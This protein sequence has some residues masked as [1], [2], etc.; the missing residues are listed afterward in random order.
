MKA[1]ARRREP[2]LMDQPDAPRADLEQSLADLRAVNRWLGGT[3]T[4]SRIVR[5]LIAAVDERPV[6]ILDVATGS[7]DLPMAIARWAERAGMDV[8]LVASDFHLA[9]LSAAR[10]Q[11]S[12][13]AQIEVAAA[14]ALRLPFS[15]DAFHIALCCTALHHF[16]DTDAVTVLRELARVA[17][18]GIVVLDLRRSPSALLGAQ[19]LA[20][21]LWRR[22]PITR[23]DGP[24]SV[25]AAF[26]S[27]ELRGMA[28][29]AGLHGATVT[30]HSFMRQSLVW[31]A[32]G[33]RS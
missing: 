19:L 25:R 5:P 14:D 32:D 31:R 23:H 1:G 24:A 15:D 11:T 26:T 22:H 12:G 4:V 8:R 7:A 16:D 17:S 18:R 27:D 20:S 6:R 13:V 2:E 21:T 29:D 10:L 28:E 30:T 33:R 9:T 3:R